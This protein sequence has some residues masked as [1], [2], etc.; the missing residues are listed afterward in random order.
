MINRLYSRTGVPYYFRVS[1]HNGQ[2]YGP[3]AYTAP[4]FVQPANNAPAAPFAPVLVGSNATSITLA[5]EHPV[6][7]GGAPV[8]GYYVEMD[9]WRGGNW[10]L[11]YDGTFF[12]PFR[13]VSMPLRRR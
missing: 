13:A 11:V 12:H 2:S 1:A 4:P 10:R 7:T 8:T 9:T 6:E 3:R 5:W